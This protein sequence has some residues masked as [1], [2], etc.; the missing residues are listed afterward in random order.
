MKGLGRCASTKCLLTS[1]RISIALPQFA[2]RAVERR[3]LSITLGV[4]QPL[5][6]RIESSIG[7]DL[8]NRTRMASFPAG[9]RLGRTAISSWATLRPLAG[10]RAALTAW[11]LGTGRTHQ[12]RVHARE[13]GCPLLGDATYGGG[14]RA[15]AAAVAGTGAMEAVAAVERPMLHAAT[16]GFRHPVTKAWAQFESPLP[17]DFVSILNTLDAE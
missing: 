2:S 8:G 12:I 15:V 17:E 6:G 5:T 7:R 11:K 9:S 13:L 16:L 3:Y 1:D 4:A 10:G 14:P